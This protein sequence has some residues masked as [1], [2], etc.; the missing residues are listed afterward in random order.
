MA[1]VGYV[2]LLLALVLSIY[3][4]V[5]ALVGAP[6]ELINRVLDR[7]PPSEAE[8]ARHKLD[9]PG[10]IRLSDVEAA[11]RQIAGLAGRLVM[12]GRIHLPETLPVDNAA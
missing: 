12:E 8:T 7:L 6:P 2:A 5:A 4:T 3:A 11:R 10:P 1:N 9:H